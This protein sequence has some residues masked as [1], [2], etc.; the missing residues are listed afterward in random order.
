ME[1][2]TGKFLSIDLR[3]RVLTAVDG[4]MSRRAA[5]RHSGVSASSVIRWDAAGRETGSFEPKP[6]GGDMRSRRI[7][8]QRAEVMRA[9]AEER[10]QTLEELRTRPRDRGVV[11]S[12]SAL[13]RFF[14][15]RGITRK[16]T[17]HAVEENRP[18]VLKKRRDWFEAQPDLDPE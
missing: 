8:E 3:A 6:E 13:S 12:T 17:G 11:A 14:H 9:F 1:R 18:D 16:K 10:D 2:E 7:E 5:A 15:R 4:G